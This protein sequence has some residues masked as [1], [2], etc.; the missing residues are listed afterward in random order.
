MLICLRGDGTVCLY[1]GDG[2]FEVQDGESVIPLVIV[3]FS[4]ICCAL[5]CQRGKR[6]V[7]E[8]LPLLSH[9]LHY[10]T[11]LMRKFRGDE[12]YAYISKN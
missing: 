9:F 6:V 2:W 5:T 8:G 4:E 1:W 3:R 12:V 11:C 10:E 7:C